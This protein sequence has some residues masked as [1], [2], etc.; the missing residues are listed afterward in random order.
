MEKRSILLTATVSQGL[1]DILH[2]VFLIKTKDYLAAREIIGEQDKDACRAQIDFTVVTADEVYWAK[3]IEAI[4]EHCWDDPVIVF[5]DSVS[6]IDKLAKLCKERRL[7]AL[8]V[9][10]DSDLQGALAR[11]RHQDKGVLLAT[12]RFGRG[13]DLRF[14]I[15]SIVIVAFVPRSMAELTQLAGRSSRTM[16]THRCQLFA[17]SKTIQSEAM[18]SYLEAQSAEPLKDGLRVVKL[19]RGRRRMGEK[20]DAQLIQLLKAGWKINLSKLTKVIR[21]RQIDA[22]V[23][24]GEER[25]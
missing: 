6:R 10:Y 25:D 11:I 7:T 19:M 1:Q 18:E 13:V 23:I 21:P 3:L 22:F 15:D 14:K 2:S 17:V 4:E 24:E 8:T 20:N 5:L 12:R 16:R 9:K